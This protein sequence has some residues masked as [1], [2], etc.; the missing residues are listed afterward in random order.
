MLKRLLP[1]LALTTACWAVFFVNHL[2]FSDHLV[3]YGIRPRHLSSLPGII[4]SPF[5]HASLQHLL[6][7]TVPLLF[8]GG[9]LCLRSPGEF[10]GVSSV[11]IIL[12]GG[13]LWLLG[14]NAY[15][16]GASALIFCLFGYLASLA[17]FER[18]LRNLVLSV[19][20]IIAYG[21]ILRGIVPTSGA[22][23]WEGHL[24]GFFSG[25]AI[26]WFLSNIKKADSTPPARA[27]VST[28]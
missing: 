24:L 6:A 17:F 7:N 10:V 14:R 5:L 28:P 9:I 22:V 13:L 8:L 11:G 2:L 21:G 20:C 4:W 12:S 16:I 18:K 1:I 3:Q 23:S 27:P 19:I 25:I 15:H 26:A